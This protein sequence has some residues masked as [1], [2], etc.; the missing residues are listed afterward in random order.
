VT[1]FCADDTSGG[2]AGQMNYVAAG[3]SSEQLLQSTADLEDM[4]F[5]NSRA[6]AKRAHI[7][8]MNHLRMNDERDISHRADAKSSAPSAFKIAVSVA[9]GSEQKVRTS[10]IE[11]CCQV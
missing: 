2:A 7:E 1:A 9:N 6:E 11:L 5:L 8:R 3:S 4:E 10:T